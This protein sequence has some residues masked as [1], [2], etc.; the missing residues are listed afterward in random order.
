M[1]NNP[2]SN[3]LVGTITRWF[4]NVVPQGWALCDGTLLSISL[5]PDLFSMLGTRYGG[6]GVTTFAL[7]K[8]CGIMPAVIPGVAEVTQL[9]ITAGCITAGSVIV[10]LNGTQYSVNVAAADTVEQVASEVAAVINA[11]VDYTAT[12]SSNVAT[13]T[14]KNA[15]A[16]S[17]ATFNDND[18]GV[19]A[20]VNVVTQGADQVITTPDDKV[21]NIII[22][23]Q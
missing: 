11:L 7:P 21:V 6:D 3:V 13:I 14:S 16:E 22:A 2:I 10:T 1:L 17:D 12:V 8:L 9:T 18:T 19:T 23:I 15:R 5:Y 4:S 20:T